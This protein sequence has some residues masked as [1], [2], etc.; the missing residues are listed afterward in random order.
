[1]TYREEDDRQI[2]EEAMFFGG[3]LLVLAGLVA[4]AACYLLKP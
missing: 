1:M 2:I 3:F 4:S